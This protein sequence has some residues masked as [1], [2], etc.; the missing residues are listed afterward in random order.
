MNILE[1]ITQE[2]VKFADATP[3]TWQSKRLARGL[4]VHVKNDS[5]AYKLVLSRTDKYPS[6]QEWRTVTKYWPY[7]IG[8]PHFE[9][10]FK[11]EKYF[12][13]G[14]VPKQEALV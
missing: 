2:L 6:P 5:T 8:T 10:N 12:L 1:R 4:T 9:P 14:R 11:K 7:P 13:Q 3:D